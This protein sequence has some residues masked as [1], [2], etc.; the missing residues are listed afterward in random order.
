VH[1][2]FPPEI[3]AR[4]FVLPSATPAELHFALSRFGILLFPSRYEGYGMVVA[5]A[6]RAGLAVVTTPTGAGV[7]L[8]ED[9]VSGVLVPIGDAAAATVAVTRLVEDPNLRER[10]GRAAVARAAPK[11]WN[12]TARELLAMYETVV[13]RRRSNG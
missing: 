3:A 6:M 9:G 11:T 8:I 2:A 1:R 4:V 12:A 13:R 7:D 5:E 10:L